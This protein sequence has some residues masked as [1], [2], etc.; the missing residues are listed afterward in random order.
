MKL[1]IRKL[2]SLAVA[3]RLILSMRD[4]GS[5]CISAPCSCKQKTVHEVMGYVNVKVR[6]MIQFSDLF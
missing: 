5:L 2:Y 6:Y 3:V 4:C 1:L